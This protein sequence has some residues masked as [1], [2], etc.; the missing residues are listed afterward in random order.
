MDLKI[1]NI[2]IPIV[3]DNITLK[4]SIYSTS[5]TPLK[6]PWI[7]ILS[8]FLAHR[9]SKF[10]KAFSERFVGAGYYVLAYDYRGH[11]ETA[12]EREEDHAVRK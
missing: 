1:Q 3:S 8:G 6:A 4:G 5:N 11:G 7:I 12:K 10:V 2:D 9:G